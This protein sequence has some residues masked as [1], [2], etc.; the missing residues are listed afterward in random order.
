[1]ICSI[2]NER[3]VPLKR[4]FCGK[5]CAQKNTSNC[6]AIKNT[7]HVD[8]PEF[9]EKTCDWCHNMFK[10]LWKFR[11][12]K[13]CSLEHAHK[14]QSVVVKQLMLNNN[15]MKQKLIASKMSKTRTQRFKSDSEFRKQVSQYTRKAW[16]DGKY[17][18]VKTGMCKW[19]EHTTWEGNVIKLQG[20]W[21]VAFARRLDELKIKYETHKGRWKYY[22]CNN[23]ERSYYV[24]FYIPM[25]DAYIDVK[26]AFWN[27]KQFDK[28][29]QIKLSNPEKFL[30]IAT[31]PFLD[32]WNVNVLKVQKE[33]LD[34][35]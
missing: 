32:A 33:L 15:P 3:E 25:W 16:A 27:T 24:D 18:G 26:G 7:K 29:G 23:I 17:D 6:A 13:A 28:V 12:R 35:K 8:Y 11:N 20:T 9:V 10:V 34:E 30:F 1:M 19:Y 4:K 14:L 22:D 21:E 31:K 2:C 5:I